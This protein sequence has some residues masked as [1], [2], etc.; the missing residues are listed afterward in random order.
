MR[1]IGLILAPGFALAPVAAE[2]Q[3][4]G[5]VP[6]RICRRVR[7]SLAL[8]AAGHGHEV[9][10]HSTAHRLST[11]ICGQIVEAHVQVRHGSE[12]LDDRHRPAPSSRSS[13]T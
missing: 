1:L 8:A 6:Q 10:F 2:A 4:T 5:N 12:A 9:G 13:W 3:Q 11:V 7:A